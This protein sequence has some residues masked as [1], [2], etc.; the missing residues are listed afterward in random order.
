VLYNGTQAVGQY[1]SM[2]N[3]TWSS[4]FATNKGQWRGNDHFTIGYSYAFSNTTAGAD[5]PS[6]CSN[7]SKPKA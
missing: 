2:Y 6:T 5:V 1:C 4:S 7:P 3:E